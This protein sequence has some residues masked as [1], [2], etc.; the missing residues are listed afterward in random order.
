MAIEPQMAP[1]IP[2]PPSAGEIVGC[3]E[4]CGRY[5]PGYPYPWP[6]RFRGWRCISPLERKRLG[7][8]REGDAI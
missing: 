2:S 8:E 4:K 5:E 6:Y 7:V 3:C 1:S